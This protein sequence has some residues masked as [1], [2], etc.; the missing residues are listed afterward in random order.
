MAPT[1]LTK[2]APRAAVCFWG[3]HRSTQHTHA[4]LTQN[5]LAPLREAYD[6]RVDVYVHALEIRAGGYVNPRA[7]EATPMLPCGTH[8]LL[9]ADSVRVEDQAAV[10]RALHLEQYHTQPDPWRTGYACV[11]NLVRA[12]YSL[13]QVTEMWQAAG[14]AAAYDVVVYARPDVRFLAPLPCAKLLPLIGD[15]T[16]IAPDF[17]AFGG[18][19]DR[20]AMGRPADMAVWGGARLERALEY[21]RRKPLHSESF[22]LDTCAAAG[23]TVRTAPIRF[24][25]VRVGG[26]VA[27][28][29]AALTA[30]TPEP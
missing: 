19:N 5:L 24:V 18:V 12:L 2:T 17:H 11:D 22:L 29:D 27:P 26:R 7:G 25:R 4:N 15:R 13:R 16:I 10:D 28:Q 1:N 8:T 9:H 14:G 23:I 20:F 21:S 6:G 30:A 3:L